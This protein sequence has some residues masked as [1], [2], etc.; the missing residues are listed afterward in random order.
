MG[1]AAKKQVPVLM[2]ERFGLV[3][4]KQHR[5]IVDLPATVSL[6]DAL[7]PSYWAHVAAEMQPFDEITIRAEDGSFIAYLVVGW[8]ER[9]F[10]HVKLDR[11]IDLTVSREPPTSS[12][13][14]R[15]EWKGPHMKFCVIRNSDNKF[16]RDGE[17]TEDEAKRWL[18]EYEAGA[19]K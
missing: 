15:V 18:R 2:P 3:E 14:H 8:C 16:L 7:E 13:K 10:A 11:R 4:E 1:E 9:N 19:G 5:F 6:D 17:R 12:V